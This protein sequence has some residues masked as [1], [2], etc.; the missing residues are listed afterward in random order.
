MII[1]DA[2][3][4]DN[5]SSDGSESKKLAESVVAPWVGYNEE[6]TMKAQ[7]LALSKVVLRFYF[8]TA[9][10]MKCV[11]SYIICFMEMYTITIQLLTEGCRTHE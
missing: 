9:L 4:E 1:P 11:H 10:E 8:F 7:I 2:V 3:E 5:I 6:E